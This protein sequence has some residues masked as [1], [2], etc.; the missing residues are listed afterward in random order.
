MVSKRTIKHVMNVQTQVEQ[1]VKPKRETIFHQLMD[2]SI[3]GDDF[4]PRKASDLAD[5][6]FAICTAAADTT[7]NVMGMATYQI[8]KNPKIYERLRQELADAFPDAMAEMKY[9]DL[10][11][12]PYLTAIIK[13]GQRYVRWSGFHEMS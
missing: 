9:T 10:E 1:G 7:G 4:I 13:E 5:E 11:K 8:L 3:H 12:L 2:S 6:A